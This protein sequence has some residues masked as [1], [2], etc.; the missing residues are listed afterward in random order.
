MTALGTTVCL[1][2]KLTV[3][4]FNLNKTSNAKL[5]CTEAKTV[6]YMRS[7]NQKNKVTH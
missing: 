4:L 6:L 2:M 1:T 5:C 3:N 7:W